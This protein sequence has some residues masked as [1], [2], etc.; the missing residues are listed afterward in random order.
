MKDR[1]KTIDII[2][3]IC[4]ILMVACHAGMPFQK[5]VY[6]FHMSVFFMASGYVFKDKYSSNYSSWLIFVKNRIKRLWL[7][8]FVAT[9]VFVILTN[10]FI[11]MNIYTNNP[12]FLKYVGGHNKIIQNLSVKDIGLKIIGALFFNC[13]TQLGGAFWFIKVLFCISVIYALIDLS[14]KTILPI[15]GHTVNSTRFLIIQGVVSA[16]F[17][18]IGYKLHSVLGINNNTLIMSASYYILFFLGY[19]LKTIKVRMDRIHFVIKM[20][21][22]IVSFVALIL[23]TYLDQFELGDNYYHNPLVLLIAS[24]AGWIFLYYISLMLSKLHSISVPLLFVGKHTLS[25]VVLHFMCFKIINYI[26]VWQ[27]KAPAFM[28]AAFPT[29]HLNGFWWIAYSLV[30]IIIPVI[31]AHILGRIL[32]RLKIQLTQLKKGKIQ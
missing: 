7:P 23:L 11:R 3:A 5:F 21:L 24:I 31:I 27:E 26:V 1:D 10:L 9:S 13:D 16:V 28:V 15:I 2:K 17:L 25:I 22:W 18:S 14:I 4:I 29:Y 32:D 30:G 8:Y 6:L 20:I 19:L 12:E